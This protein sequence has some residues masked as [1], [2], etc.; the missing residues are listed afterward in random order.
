MKQI[1]S[2]PEREVQKFIVIFYIVGVCGFMLPF[3]RQLFV[4]LIPYSLVLTIGLLGL[5]HRIEN[6]TKH[7]TIFS[8]VYVFGFLVEMVGVNS[9]LVFGTYTYGSGLGFKVAGTP[10]IIG[11]NWLFLVYTSAAIVERIKTNNALKILLGALLLVGYDLAL[12]QVAPK[13]D[14][15]YWEGG[16]IPLKNYL[17][18]FVIAILFHSLFKAFRINPHNPLAGILFVSQLV[19]FILLSIILP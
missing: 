7:I 8:V 10:I 3:T 19:F 4:V 6:P 2:I 1:L 14:M 15:W 12:E 5:F 18:W 9:G 13:L 11:L 16:A 17:A